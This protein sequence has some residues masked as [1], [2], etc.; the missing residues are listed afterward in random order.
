MKK[1][2][3][4][5]GIIWAILVALFNVIAFVSP[6]WERFE[7]YT[8]SFWIGYMLITACFLGHLGCTAYVL[9]G[10][11]THVIYRLRLLKI[12]RTG[13]IWS[14]VVGGV[15]MLISPL[16]YWIA[17]LFCALVLAVTALALA[18]VNLAAETVTEVEDNVAN[19]TQFIKFLAVDAENLLHRAKTEE[20]KAACK[21]V[22]EA[23]RYSD[24]MSSRG[25]ESI[26]KEISSKMGALS[27]LI[28]QNNEGE[29][30]GVAQE[31]VN[32]IE[33]RNRESRA[34]K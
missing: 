25:L 32:L 33:A 15:E 5:Y 11:R 10:K 2:F 3:R 34:L 30:L 19:K 22:Y 6:G 7:K 9:F 17:A 14:F 23:A 26:E 18:K 20:T 1:T 31:V 24:P 21:K 8:S 27:Y 4:A 16:P 13:L 28:D 12:S 29:A